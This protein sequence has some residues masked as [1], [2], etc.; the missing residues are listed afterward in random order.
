MRATT[1]ALSTRQKVPVGAPEAWSKWSS[2]AEPFKEDAMGAVTRERTTQHH[3]YDGQH[4][5]CGDG[6]HIVLTART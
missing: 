1:S 2:G 6:R 3:E 5:L 4:H